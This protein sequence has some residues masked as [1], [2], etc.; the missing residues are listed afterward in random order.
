MRI[1]LRTWRLLILSWAILL[2]PQMAFVHLL[3]HALPQAEVQD[4]KSDAH[5]VATKVCSTC[6]AFAQLGTALPSGCVATEDPPGTIAAAD[7]SV[8]SVDSRRV[9]A[10]QARG[11]PSLPT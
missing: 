7:A 10:F 3:S 9:D 4:E 2:A 11:P 1:L 6:C 5:A 8:P